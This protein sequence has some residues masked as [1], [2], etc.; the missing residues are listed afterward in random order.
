MSANPSYT[1]ARLHVFQGRYERPLRFTFPFCYTPH[2]MCVAAA[3]EVQRHID[4]SGV[5]QYEHGHGKMFGVLVVDCGDGGTGFLA[6]YSGLLAGRNDWPYFVPPVFDARQPGGYFRMREQQIVD[7]NREI[8]RCEADPVRLALAEEMK[9]V[10]NEARVATDDYRRQMKEARS[11]R[12]EARRAGVS[13]AEEERLKRESQFMKAEL[14]RM[15]HRYAERLD[16]IA[17][18]LRP[19]NEH[20]EHLRE[21]RRDMS[22]GLQEWLFRR[23]EMLNAHGERRHLLDIFASTTAGVP[24]AGTG[25]CCAPKLLQYAYQRGYRPLCMAE[26]WW[27]EAPA[28]ELRR[29][30]HFYPSC[31]GKCGPLLR[32]MMQGLDVEPDPLGNDFSGQLKI[33]YEDDD[34]VV[35]DKPHGMLSVPGRGDSVSALTLMCARYGGEG[36]VLAVHRLDMDTGGLLVM[37]RTARAQRLLHAQFEA[38]TV[39][40]RYTALLDG[41]PDCPRE[42]TIDLPLSA[43]FMDR[44]RQRVDMKEGKR[45][46]TRYEIVESRGGRTLVHLYPE[47]GRTH[48]LRVHCAHKD[49]LGCPI[50]GDR[51]YGHAGRRLC[52]RATSISFAHPSTGKTMTFSVDEDFAEEIAQGTDNGVPRR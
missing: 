28:T 18:R 12:E 4:D 52:L 33:V 2:P 1:D 22:D 5:L 36:G 49:G 27:G 42:G 44:P 50:T 46:V 38:H 9:S 30:G 29:H 25:D 15:K 47:T 14:R 43:D 10:E 41:T 32:Y 8:E 48:Q 17:A 7:V 45:A 31:T 19:L 34:L 51:L 39:K 11:R 23:Y 3:R 21:R 37:A 24:P 35:V 20:L 13:E 40:K 16:D 26:F 6:A